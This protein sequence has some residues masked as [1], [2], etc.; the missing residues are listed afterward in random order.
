[1]SNVSQASEANLVSDYRRRQPPNIPVPV[2]VLVLVAIHQ[3]VESS[4]VQSSQFQ[5]PSRGLVNDLL[6]TLLCSA[7]P[8]IK[9][10]HLTHYF[11]STH[12]SL[13]NLPTTPTPSPFDSTPAYPPTATYSSSPHSP[14]LPFN[15]DYHESPYH[16]RSSVCH[17][18]LHISILH[19]GIQ[20]THTTQ[21]SAAR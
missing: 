16:P 11:I 15:S 3:S 7:L 18:R 9:Q 12:F 13:L 10:P 2:L 6:R 19:Y 8:C 4:P 14:S 21:P 1:M 5:D 20:H 17:R